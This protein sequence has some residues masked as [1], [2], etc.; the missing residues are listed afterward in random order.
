MFVI[1]A[2]K[3]LPNTNLN[4]TQFFKYI[5]PFFTKDDG[6]GNCVPLSINDNFEILS[7]NQYYSSPFYYKFRY[8]NLKDVLF[9]GLKG[10]TV[11]SRD[12]NKFLPNVRGDSFHNT[13]HSGRGYLSPY[14]V[15]VRDETNDTDY[16]TWAKIIDYKNMKLIPLYLVTY[17]GI[18]SADTARQYYTDLV[19]K[20]AELGKKYYPN[21]TSEWG[22]LGE[23]YQD[24]KTGIIFL[25]LNA[26]QIRLDIPFD[27][28]IISDYNKRL[29]EDVQLSTIQG[30][31]CLMPEYSIPDEY[32]KQSLG[33]ET[34]GRF[35]V[36]PMNILEQELSCYHIIKEPL[37]NIGLTV[38]KIDY[39]LSRWQNTISN[40]FC[41]GKYNQSTNEVYQDFVLWN[42]ERSLKANFR[43]RLTQNAAI[44]EGILEITD[45]HKLNFIGLAG[46]YNPIRKMMINAQ[47]YTTPK[48]KDYDYFTLKDVPL[49]VYIDYI[50][51]KLGQ[52]KC[53]N[54]IACLQRGYTGKTLTKNYD[55]FIALFNGKENI[56]TSNISLIDKFRVCGFKDLE[57]YASILQ[58]WDGTIFTNM[59]KSKIEN[60]PAIDTQL[61]DS[62]FDYFNEIL[63]EASI[64]VV[65][66]SIFKALGCEDNYYERL[67]PTKCII[68][69]VTDLYLYTETGQIDK[70][71]PKY[72]NEQ[73]EFVF[74]IYQFEKFK[75]KYWEQ[76]R[77]V[78][79]DTKR[80]NPTDFKN[81]REDGKI[82]TRYCGTVAEY[83]LTMWEPYKKAVIC[84][85]SLVLDTRIDGDD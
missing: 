74:D 80:A 71:N 36:Y 60:R 61:I 69:E 54:S 26:R 68:F 85:D 11:L 76:V 62:R 50:N 27:K 31:Y 83:Y 72:I 34:T 24:N 79:W 30:G 17:Y 40:F 37:Q 14:L 15:F 65:D 1:A 52:Q 25:K 43:K 51:N 77:E 59:S 18:G 75:V 45:E 4:S 22:Y 7:G 19:N 21:D 28:A 49:D 8:L 32:K 84:L 73:G 57:L 20:L 2:N 29:S 67:M 44:E 38:F 39:G 10:K 48:N 78:V 9:F 42:G 41:Q 35:S 56:D 16:L 82:L 33:R 46:I 55:E 63:D 13:P 12:K 70:F 58:Y 66:T 3:L 64:Y 6:N 23:T 53:I 47:P 81:L 5:E